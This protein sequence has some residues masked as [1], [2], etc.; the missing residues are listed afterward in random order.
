MESNKNKSY[1][2]NEPRYKIDGDEIAKY[3]NAEKIGDY[4]QSNSLLNNIFVRGSLLQAFEE[5]NTVI[6]N[7]AILDKVNDIKQLIKRKKGESS[8]VSTSELVNY[9]LSVYFES[10]KDNED[11]IRELFKDE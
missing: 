7:P 3:L 6:L 1:I 9:I 4:E 11:L 10:K 8:N 2:R 5:L